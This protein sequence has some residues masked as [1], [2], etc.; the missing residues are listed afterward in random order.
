MKQAVH[1]FEHRAGVR[2]WHRRLLLLVCWAVLL[3]LPAAPAVLADRLHLKGGAVIEVDE[4]WESADGVWYK[5]GDVTTF[6]SRERV[7]RIERAAQ[8]VAAGEAR[9]VADAT[10]A[11]PP[12]AHEEVVWIYLVGGARMQVDEAAESADGVW[13]RRG[14]LSAVL[15]TARV[16]RVARDTPDAAEQVAAAHGR[17][18]YQWTTG[19]PRLDGLIKESGARHGLDPYLIFCVMEHE[20][21]FNARAVSPVGARGLMQLMP[22]TARRFGVRNVFDPA[23]NINGGTR[24]L[25]GLVAMFGG[26][27]D[28]VLA[29]YN[30]GEG[31]VLRYG[32]RVPPYAE[33][34]NYVRRISARYGDGTL[35]PAAATKP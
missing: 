34:R 10:P 35:A 13:Y 30:A 32:Q 26:R 18:V 28:L 1:R 21:H 12:A 27:L 29:S 9:G 2:C 14:N 4:A 11:P 8:P 20:S 16:E 23:Q 19:N 7:S 6:I 3:L 33:T 5:R 31:A 17:R 25:K 15:E 22:G 24:Y